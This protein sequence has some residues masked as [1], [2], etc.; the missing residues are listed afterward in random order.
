MVRLGRRF[1]HFTSLAS[2]KARNAVISSLLGNSTSLAYGKT[3]NAIR[4][5]LGHST[6]LAC[7]KARK[8]AWKFY[9][10]CLC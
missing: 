3:R 8:A 2:G 9:Q 10:L 5:L 4:S 6:S 1:G 7:G